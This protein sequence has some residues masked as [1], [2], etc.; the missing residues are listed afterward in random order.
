MFGLSV[1][2]PIVIIAILVVGL[3]VFFAMRRRR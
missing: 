2:I 1:G 3:I